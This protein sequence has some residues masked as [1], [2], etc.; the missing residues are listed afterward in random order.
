M[1]TRALAREYPPIV[2]VEWFHIRESHRFVSNG[3]RKGEQSYERR[4]RESSVQREWGWGAQHWHQAG[5]GQEARLQALSGTS[6]GV[7][8][9][10]SVAA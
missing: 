4:K 1:L 3:V 7:A 6:A 8:V 10:S 2:K 5:D 9:S